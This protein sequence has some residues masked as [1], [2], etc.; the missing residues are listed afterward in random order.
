MNRKDLK[1]TIYLFF[2]FIKTYY[3]RWCCF[4]LCDLIGGCIQFGD[5]FLVCFPLR[6]SR[7]YS[8][9]I[10]FPVSSWCFCTC[11]EMEQLLELNSL[12]TDTTKKDSS[13][14]WIAENICRIMLLWVYIHSCGQLCFWL[15]KSAHIQA[16]A[17]LRT[18]AMNLSKQFLNLQFFP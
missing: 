15:L 11:I 9:N 1:V 4:F 16:H 5:L 8:E 7:K 3:S 12:H 2:I 18:K 13:V 17:H 10:L 14:K 6:L